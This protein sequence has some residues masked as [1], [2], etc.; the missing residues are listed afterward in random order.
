[1]NHL[2]VTGTIYAGVTVEVAGRR[3]SIRGGESRPNRGNP[4]SDDEFR[5]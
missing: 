4:T 3:H 1:M 5:T 2:V